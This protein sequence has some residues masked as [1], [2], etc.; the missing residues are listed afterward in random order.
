ME[1]VRYEWRTGAQ[2]RGNWRLLLEK[3]FAIWEKSEENRQMEPCP[4]LPTT[5]RISRGQ[6]LVKTCRQR[7]KE[8][9]ERIRRAVQMTSMSL[10][11]VVG[12]AK[13]HA[14]AEAVA[15]EGAMRIS[16][17]ARL[18]SRTRGLTEHLCHPEN[19]LQTADGQ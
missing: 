6:H 19:L 13:P 11:A 10:H 9:K 4:D 16:E 2:G 8:A 3:V 7:F 5:T 17:L 1:R 12:K 14:A 15:D 18:V